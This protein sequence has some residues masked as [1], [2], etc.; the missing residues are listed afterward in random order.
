MLSIIGRLLINE[1]STRDKTPRDFLLP[2]IFHVI[3]FQVSLANNGHLIR[4]LHLSS[5]AH[6]SSVPQVLLFKRSQLLLFKGPREQTE[7][8]QYKPKYVLVR[9]I[10]NTYSIHQPPPQTQR[11][12]AIYPKSH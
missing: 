11:L 6:H 7:A 5:F 2:G 10:R 3:I 8:G 9:S 4:R 1:G 12:P